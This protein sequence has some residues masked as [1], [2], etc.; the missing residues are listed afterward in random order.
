MPD[1]IDLI[2]DDMLVG[3]QNSPYN[4]LVAQADALT[5]KTNGILQGRVTASEFGHKLR[6]TFTIIARQL[7]DY[8]YHLFSVLCGDVKDGYYPVQF[9]SFWD[10]PV[11][12]TGEPDFVKRLQEI[13]TSEA[14]RRVVSSMM[15]R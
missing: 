13:F 6:Y 3:D 9:L 1:I 12:A 15:S 5:R 11:L 7:N 4:I 8:E 14:F 10:G 2:P